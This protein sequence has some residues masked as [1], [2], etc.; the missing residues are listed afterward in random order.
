MSAVSRRAL[1]VAVGVM[2]AMLDVQRSLAPMSTVTYCTPCAAASFSCPSRSAIVAPVRAKLKP[3]PLIAGLRATILWYWLSTAGSI[4]V[5][6]EYCAQSRRTHPLHVASNPRVIESP[7]EAI[8]LGS[9]TPAASTGTTPSA[10]I[11]A[12]ATHHATSA[13]IR[14]GPIIAVSA[15]VERA[16]HVQDRAGARH[17]RD[18]DVVDRSAL[19]GLHLDGAR[20]ARTVGGPTARVA[21]DLLVRLHPHARVA[22]PL[23]GAA[24]RLDLERGGVEARA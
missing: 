9:G 6:H 1:N 24:P 10:A 16:A 20:A 7:V 14:T 12:A 17:R 5:D 21:R 13:L 8:E 19:V 2:V 18:R 15:A 11:A 22:R 3:W 23:H 4:P